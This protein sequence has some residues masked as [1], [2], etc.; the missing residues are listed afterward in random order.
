VRNKTT[1]QLGKA[2]TVNCRNAGA[3]VN[4][5]M[6]ALQKTYAN[7]EMPIFDIKY[8]HTPKNW[9][10]TD[11]DDRSASFCQ[12]GDGLVWYYYYWEKCNEWYCKF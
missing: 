1:E 7:T 11:M 3:N 8:L 10:N 2:M 6:I 5:F 9:D 4:D 12:M